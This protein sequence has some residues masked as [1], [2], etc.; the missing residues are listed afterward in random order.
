MSN[1][2]TTHAL[3]LWLDKQE[4]EIRDILNRHQPDE[5]PPEL[6]EELAQIAELKRGLTS[7]AMILH[8][9]QMILD[10]PLTPVSLMHTVYGWS[11]AHPHNLT[12]LAG[13]RT[14]VDAV[15]KLQPLGTMSLDGAPERQVEPGNWTELQSRP[16]ITE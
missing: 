15:S 9:E 13:G 6:A 3:R 5:V 11:L 1:R 12:S 14:L 4:A 7:M 2:P 8:M 10:D 16:S